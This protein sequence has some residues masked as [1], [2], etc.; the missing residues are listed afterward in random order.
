M[1]VMWDYMREQF[2][3]NEPWQYSVDVKIILPEFAEDSTQVPAMVRHKIPDA[4]KLILFAD[5]NPIQHIA[6]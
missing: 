6:T 4:R 1:D 5:L 3:R 2:I